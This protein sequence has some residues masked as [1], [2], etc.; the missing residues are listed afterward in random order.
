MG[1]ISVTEAAQLARE[2]VEQDLIF[3]GLLIME[4][5]LKPETAPTM[6][7]LNAAAVKSVMVTGTPWHS[8]T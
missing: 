2:V 4:N 7:Q 3:V 8:C 5:K 6:L 1:G